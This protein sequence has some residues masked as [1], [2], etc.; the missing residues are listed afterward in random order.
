MP[1]RR[2]HL[3]HEPHGEV[4]QW[5]WRIHN[6][7]A[8]DK[9][10][11]YALPELEAL[12]L[13]ATIEERHPPIPYLALRDSR[14]REDVG[15]AQPAFHAAIE[16]LVE[17]GA[18]EEMAHEGSALYCY[19]ASPHDLIVGIDLKQPWNENDSKRQR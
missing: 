4:E 1:K 13:V 9:D 14:V 10:N 15:Q 6:L 12:I 8:G 2:D 3:E 5:H 16:E 19:K 11:A 17:C 18:V 7:L